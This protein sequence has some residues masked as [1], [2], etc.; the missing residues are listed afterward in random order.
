MASGS[1]ISVPNKYQLCNYGS[2]MLLEV[3]GPGLSDIH[4]GDGRLDGAW[5]RHGHFVLLKEDGQV[6]S[7]ERISCTWRPYAI[8]A[9]FEFP[10]GCR[11][12]QKSWV[13]HPFVHSKCTIQGDTQGAKLAIEGS[14]FAA[15]KVFVSP[16]NSIITEEMDPS[17]KPLALEISPTITP[18][19]VLLSANGENWTEQDFIWS[20]GKTHY[21]LIYNSLP[22]ELTISAHLSETPEFLSAQ[23]WKS[24]RKREGD[25]KNEWISAYLNEYPDIECPDPRIRDLFQM[26]LYV[27]RSNVM[28]PGGM[29]P[30]SFVV[31]SKITY[32]MWWMWD[33]AFH[34]MID[35]WMMDPTLAYGNLLNHTILQS[36]KGCIPDAAGKYYSDTGEGKWIHPEHYD[37]FP[38][39]STGP[40][41]QGIAVW[42]VYQKTGNL[43]LLKRLYPHLVMY[44][45]WLVDEKASG[46]DPDLIAFKNWWDVGWDSSKRM[47]KTGHPADN[48]DWD[49]PIV[50]VEG[51]VFLCILR[52]TLSKIAQILGDQ[53]RSSEYSK[54]SD[55][56]RQA[57]DKFL[58]NEQAGFYFDILPEGRMLNVWTPAGFTPLLAKIPDA[59]RYNRMREHLLDPN[60]FWTKYPLP[61]LSMDDEDFNVNSWWE[62]CTWPVINWLVNDGL[63]DYDPETGLK[64]LMKTIDMMTCKGYPTCSEYYN[65]LNGEPGGAADQGWGAMP[66]D[67][68]LHRIFGLYHSPDRLVLNP[69]LPDEW[70]EASVRNIPAAGTSID[71]R[72]EKRDGELKAI[73]K[74]TGSKPMTVV[75]KNSEAVLEPSIEKQIG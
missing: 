57:I 22:Q 72:Y 66:V 50:P 16:E 63:F 67:L 38:P 12:S 51:N 40:C 25:V 1:I 7:A 48:I 27:Q 8:E 24:T 37:D 42:D 60:K 59:E 46:I 18:D 19:Q 68:I 65:P 34:S 74:N 41:N 32:P 70:N 49:L 5:A 35:A 62:G 43:D 31:P 20:E 55:R 17:F 3:R 9:E 52:D 53:P 44:E 14:S 13:D 28:L 26:C 33:T 73:V 75:F 58:W 47:G 30:Y 64:L 69:Y 21:R 15:A 23:Q 54:A 29:L 6:I 56:T 39:A 45:R 61:T 71:L 2:F 11:I 10:G 36:R 4:Y